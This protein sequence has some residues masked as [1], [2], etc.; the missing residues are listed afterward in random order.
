MYK[1]ILVD[2][3][4]RVR[5]SICALLDWEGLGLRLLGSCEN[6]LDAL[7]LITDERPDILLTDIRMPVMDGLELIGQA[8][9]M[10]REEK[11]SFVVIQKGR[12][13]YQDKGNGVKPI[14]KLL[15]SQKELLRDAVI[16]DKLIGKA[17]A[18][19][20]CLGEVKYVYGITMSE[21]GKAYLDQ[22]GVAAAC[23]K[24]IGMISNRKRDGICPLERAV[25]D[26]EDP[27]TAYDTLKET[28]A[29]LMKTAG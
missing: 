18:L 3:E 9:Q 1:V 27:Q 10:I 11:C 12:I 29:Q 14:M 13:V 21:A 24:C 5:E 8:K 20:L 16:V 7:Q 19:L 23:D 17:A 28:I 22:A 4:T 25:S 26:I 15:D 6:A 2:D